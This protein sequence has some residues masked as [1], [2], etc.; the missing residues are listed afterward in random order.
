MQI[1]SV[2]EQPQRDNR[3]YVVVVGGLGNDIA[4]Y[5]D[6][7]YTQERGNSYETIANSGTKLTERMFRETLGC[8]D[9]ES[10]GFYYRA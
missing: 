1:L 10:D 8:W 4:C 3:I 9:F 2:F 7:E 6:N 5:C